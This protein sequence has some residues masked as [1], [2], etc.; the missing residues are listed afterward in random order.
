MLKHQIEMIQ[1][2]NNDNEIGS[3][4][5]SNSKLSKL[6]HV[7]SKSK[8]PFDL[9]TNTE[10]KDILDSKTAISSQ[11]DGKHIEKKDSKDKSIAE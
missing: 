7:Q 2:S 5:Y 8:K 10:E 1:N 3:N 6:N 11:L 9:T 4:S